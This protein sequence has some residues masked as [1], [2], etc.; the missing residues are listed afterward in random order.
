MSE[1]ALPPAAVALLRSLRDSFYDT[2]HY[3]QAVGA[4][5][6]KDHPLRY[7]ERQALE[8]R[9]AAIARIDEFLKN[10]GEEI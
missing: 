1:P 10:H 3:W 5:Y 7:A 6:G 8:L 4:Y 9:D 2:S